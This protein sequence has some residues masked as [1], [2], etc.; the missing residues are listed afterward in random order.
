MRQY[1][2]RV[3]DSLGGFDHWELQQIPRTKN[4][5]VDLISRLTQGVE[6]HLENLS[7]I[8]RVVDVDTP[9]NEW[10]HVLA[11]LPAEDEWMNEVI[12][13]KTHGTTPDYPL[14]KRKMLAKV[15]SYKL[16]GGRLY[17]T[18]FGGP[19]L[20]CLTRVEAS[21]VMNE[22]HQGICAAHQEARTVVP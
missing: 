21:Q 14:Q 17:K 7:R 20:R 1:K 12:L 10:D 8:A 22:I 9:S 18:S 2:E 4:T 5:V 15:P 3:L 16:V 19:L 6:E 11:I 13:F